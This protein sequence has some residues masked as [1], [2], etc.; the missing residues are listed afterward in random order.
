MIVSLFRRGQFSSRRTAPARCISCCCRDSGSF[1]GS[2]DKGLQDR[3]RLALACNLHPA[4]VFT[5][6]GWRR[7]RPDRPR[8]RSSQQGP[9]VGQGNCTS[10]HYSI[11]TRP[12]GLVESL[13][14]GPDQL[15]AVAP[16]LWKA[17]NPTADGKAIQRLLV[18]ERKFVVFDGG[19]DLL[20]RDPG[21]GLGPVRQ[22]QQELLTAET[23]KD[24]VDP[25]L[26]LDQSCQ[27]L[28]QPIPCHM[29]V[30]IV[31]VLEMV[32]VE[33]EHSK[34]ASCSPRHRRPTHPI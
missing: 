6:V 5:G 11:A 20:S 13:I 22:N 25:D 33:Q 19:T 31:V 16:V 18:T 1:R 9:L 21:L 14:G 28:Q 7:T 23:P 12:L 4:D 29:T 34:T 27:R 3:P 30:D 15:G 24:V 10:R 2:T 17:G 32:D 26:L 8:H